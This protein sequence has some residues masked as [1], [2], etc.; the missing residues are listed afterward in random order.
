MATDFHGLRLIAFKILGVARSQAKVPPAQTRPLDRAFFER[1]PR[2]V[3]RELLGKVLV[4]EGA[5]G[6][7]TARIVEVE[8]YLGVNDPAAHAAAGKT[9]RNSVLFGPPGHAYI[10]FIYGNHYCLNVSCE[11]EGRAG[12]VLFRALEPLWGIEEMARARGMKIHSGKVLSDKDFPKLTSGP[13]RLCEALCIT[14]QRD[15]DCDLT[16]AE[17]GLWI[18]DDGFRVGRIALSPRIGI[19]K[20]AEHPLRYFLAGNR[21]V[22]GRKTP[23]AFDTRV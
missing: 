5:R 10:Y 12:S 14:R 2:R 1:N 7:L 16:S 23:S 17:S 20:A 3:A 8:A 13:G 9:L 6:Q 22:S 21:F 18:G 4:R 15:N 19:T 11:P